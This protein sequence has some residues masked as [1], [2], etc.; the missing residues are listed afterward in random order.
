MYD[1]MGDSIAHLRDKTATLTDYNVLVTILTD[2]EE[3]ASK[4]YNGKDIKAMVE[5]LK[6][7]NWTF[8]YIGANHDV[9]KFAQSIAINNTMSFEA[10]AADLIECLKRKSMPE[11]CSAK[12]SAT[13]KTPW[14]IFMMRITVRSNI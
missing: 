12:R 10:D 1:A 7:K 9:E 8:T 2:G 3:N 6:S 14:M 13:K 5:E 11:I 4:E